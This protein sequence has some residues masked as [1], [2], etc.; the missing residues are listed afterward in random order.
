M[1]SIHTPHGGKLSVSRVLTG[2]IADGVELFAD[3][4]QCGKVSG[5]YTL[6]GKDQTEAAF[7]QGTGDTVAL[8][9]LDDITHRRHPDQR[10][11]RLARLTAQS[12][13][14]GLFLRA[15]P[16]ERKDEV[17]L[18]AAIHRSG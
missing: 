17:K 12:A 6:V 9:K 1:K 11:E 5:I 3:G 7:G 13:S 14:T 16:K 18:S 10:E 4:R 8:G 2:S 15:R